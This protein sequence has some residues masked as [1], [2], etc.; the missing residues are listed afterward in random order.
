[1]PPSSTSPVK[2]ATVAEWIATLLDVK[3]VASSVRSTRDFFLGPGSSLASV[4][5][6]ELA[7]D[8]LSLD[9]GSVVLP[10]VVAAGGPAISSG[11]CVLVV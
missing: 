2:N 10:P 1:M 6:T 3:K 7:S 8:I 11:T 4:V 5:S 9:A